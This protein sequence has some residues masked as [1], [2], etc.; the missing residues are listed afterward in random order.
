[1]DATQFLTTA[2]GPQGLGSDQAACLLAP[3]LSPPAVL[4]RRALQGSCLINNPTHLGSF[5]PDL[6][7][8]FAAP[9]I[10]DPQ[11]PPAGSPSHT[12]VQGPPAKILAAPAPSPPKKRSAHHCHTHTSTRF[13]CA[14]FLSLL[15]SGPYV[16]ISYATSMKELGL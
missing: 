1:M 3:S 8:P 4:S 5:S 7:L 12:G 15:K 2:L 11:A 6:G 16:I 13:S 9:P 10:S 14:D